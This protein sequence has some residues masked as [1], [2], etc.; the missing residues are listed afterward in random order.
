MAV[1]LALLLVLVAAAS[2]HARVL[3]APSVSAAVVRTV[4]PA[5]LHRLR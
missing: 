5:D 3:H 2:A 4:A 1:A